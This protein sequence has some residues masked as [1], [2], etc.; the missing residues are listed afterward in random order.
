VQCSGSHGWLGGWGVHGP[1]REVEEQLPALELARGGGEGGE[2]VPIVVRD[3][4]GR[5]ALGV[6]DE[7]CE[8]SGGLPLSAARDGLQAEGGGEGGGKGAGGGPGARA[9]ER[10]G[11]PGAKGVPWRRP[12][13][14]QGQPPRCMCVRCSV[15]CALKGFL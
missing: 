14:G 11:R 2:D 5:G 7:A 15:P 3:E 12:A 4:D 6:Q 1:V 10:R 13:W 8:R 9:R